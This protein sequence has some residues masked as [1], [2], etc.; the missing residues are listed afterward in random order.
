MN[1]NFLQG[2]D[3]ADYVGEQL[4]KMTLLISILMAL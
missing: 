2:L 3:N 1:G 4:W